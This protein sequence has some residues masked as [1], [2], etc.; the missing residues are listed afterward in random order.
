LSSLDNTTITT[1]TVRLFEIDSTGA[2]QPVSASVN[3]TGGG[4]AINLTPTTTLQP[5]G[6]YRCNVDGVRDLAGAEILPF[7][8]EVN[9]G[10][11]Q[12]G[13]S[14]LDGVAIT[15]AGAVATGTRA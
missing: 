2:Q 6:H 8:I 7:S 3:G 4:D 10:A 12:G 15:N 5:D 14:P 1:E 11:V 13:P 9:T